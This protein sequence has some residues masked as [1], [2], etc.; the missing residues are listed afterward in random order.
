MLS[1]VNLRKNFN[2]TAAIA[3][4]TFD[5]PDNQVTCLLAPSGAGKSTLLRILAGLETPTSGIVRV[6]GDAIVGPSPMAVLV[7]QVDALFPHL[8]VR[9]QVKFG[10][11]LLRN[12]QRLSD[13]DA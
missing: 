12:R 9:D 8:R 1:V 4:L 2:D 3:D 13:T 6:D 10:T 11:V 5:L 7:P